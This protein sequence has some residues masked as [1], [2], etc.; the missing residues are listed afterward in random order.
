V[1]LC[2]S[3]LRPRLPQRPLLT[4]L[5]F[6]TATPDR[7][8]AQQTARAYIVVVRERAST[9]D[10]SATPS[11]AECAPIR[12]APRGGDRVIEDEGRHSFAQPRRAHL[13]SS[14]G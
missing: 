14:R 11:S 6:Q 8:T 4:H 7:I 13:Q 12:E 9:V 2:F 1:A 5:P 10:A 3:P